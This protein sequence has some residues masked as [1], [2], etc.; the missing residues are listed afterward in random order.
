MKLRTTFLQKKLKQEK[1]IS[2]IRQ[3]YRV[4]KT[5]ISPLRHL[6]LRFQVPELVSTLLLLFPQWI[7][8]FLEPKRLRSLAK[9]QQVRVREDIRNFQSAHDVQKGKKKKK[10]QYISKR[11]CHASDSRSATNLK[12]SQKIYRNERLLAAWN[13]GQD[14][15][16]FFFF[17]GQASGHVGS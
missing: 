1:L 15:L 7:Y 5:K 17:F 3:W 10:V 11:A 6:A 8:E 12:Q 9:K 16:F 14:S 2:D 13:W 4:R